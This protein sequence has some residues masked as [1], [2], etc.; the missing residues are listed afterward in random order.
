MDGWGRSVRVASGVRWVV[1][2]KAVGE[3]IVFLWYLLSSGVGVS[4]LQC[5]CLVGVSLSMHAK[6]GGSLPGMLTNIL[7][8]MLTRC[9]VIHIRWIDY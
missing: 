4:V 8:N 2:Y 9:Y 1:W 5:A 3:R 7:T 6:L